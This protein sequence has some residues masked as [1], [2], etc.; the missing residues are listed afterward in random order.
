MTGAKLAMLSWIWL[1][2]A[3][4]PAQANILIQIDQSTQRMSV[5][6]DGERLY[7]WRVS[8]GRPG[9]DTPNGKFRPNRMDADHFS[10]EY[11]NAPM[12]DAIF[13]DLH[14]H[15]IHGSYDP[16]G[17]PAAS[18]GCVRLDPANA[19]KLFDLVKEEGMANTTVEITGDVTVALRNSKSAARVKAARRHTLPSE[20]DANWDEDAQQLGPSAPQPQRG[21]PSYDYAAP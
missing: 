11:D 18:H 9:Y 2:G 3:A 14:G 7:E 15:A 16:V 12:P 13:F 19:A 8:T 21:Y 17:H 1:A 10:E 6:V 20:P 4:L 5:D